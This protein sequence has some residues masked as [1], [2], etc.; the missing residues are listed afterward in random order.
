MIFEIHVCCWIVLGQM[1][2]FV[3]ILAVTISDQKMHSWEKMTRQYLPRFPVP[4][5]L[6]K[7]HAAYLL[8]NNLQSMHINSQEYAHNTKYTY[9]GKLLKTLRLMTFISCES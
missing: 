6:Y 4:E 7:M 9:N 8:Q 3:M 1:H 5:E 2:A